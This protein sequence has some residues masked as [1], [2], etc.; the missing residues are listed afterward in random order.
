M[1]SPVILVA[2]LFFTSSCAW[3]AEPPTM[4]V[5]PSPQAK[6][7]QT[8]TY[9]PGE[10]LVQVE[11][12]APLEQVEGIAQAAG[13]KVER[14]IASWGLYLFRFDPQVPVEEIIRRLEGQPGV[15]YAEPNYEV[16]VF[17]H[18]WDG[19]NPAQASA[20]GTPVVVAVLDT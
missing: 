11:E 7:G 15:V 1:R 6:T 20:E 5:D 17:F 4:P 12:G 8:P 13:A 2:L 16:E 18:Q 10:V 3:A 14:P 19:D 9:L